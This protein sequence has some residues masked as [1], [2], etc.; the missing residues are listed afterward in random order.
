MCVTC[1]VHMFGYYSRERKNVESAKKHV[2]SVDLIG[3]IQDKQIGLM[4]WNKQQNLQLNVMDSQ[5]LNPCLKQGLV[6]G[7]VIGKPGVT[8]VPKFA[9]LPP[10]TEAFTENV[11]RAHLQ[12]FLWKNALQLD[13]QKLYSTDYGWMK[14]HSTKSLQP[15]TVPSDTP[16][17]P[18][19]ILQMI[20]CTCSSETPCN[21]SRC[22]CNR[23]KLA[24]TMFCACQTATACYT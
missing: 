19:K 3:N 2:A 9:S 4:C 15:T 10:T 6:C 5:W 11:K 21:S 18:S 20:R 17:A 12:T 8:H 1:V 22:G 23:A 14:E 24:C 16:L 13:P 7:P